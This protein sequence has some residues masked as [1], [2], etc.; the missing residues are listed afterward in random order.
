MTSARKDKQRGDIIVNLPRVFKALNEAADQFGNPF[1]ERNIA[2]REPFRVLIACLLSLRTK[3]ETTAEAADRLFAVADSPRGIL[4]VPEEEIARL[5]YPVGFY[6]RKAATL[7]EVCRLILEEWN[8]NAPDTME[9]LLSLPG[10]GRKTANLTLSAGFGIP[11]ICVDTHV[12]R[13]TN[14]WGMVSAPTPDKT[15]MELRRVLP[16]SY[17]MAIN[18]LLVIYGRNICMPISPKCSQCRLSDLC[19]RIGVQRSR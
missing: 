1:I 14:R 4:A 8:G 5:I 9:G 11:A 6:R 16:K 13:I 10:V 18:H 12:H 7:R 2:G 3:D 19:P 15:E 17:W